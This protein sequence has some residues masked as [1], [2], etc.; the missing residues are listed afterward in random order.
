MQESGAGR[1]PGRTDF[2]SVSLSQTDRVG[3]AYGPLSRE[4]MDNLI[5]LDFNLGQF[6]SFLDDQVGA[7]NYIVALTGDHGVMNAPE[8]EEGPGRRLGARERSLLQD[9]LSAAAREAT[10]SGENGP[11]PRMVEAMKPL[12]FVGP[13]FAHEDLQAAAPGDSIQGF[14]V[15][16]F[17]PGRAGGLL[18]TYGVEMTWAENTISW[19]MPKGTTH[20]SP[21]LY[22]RWVPLFLMGMG[23]ERGTVDDPVQPIDLAP[24]LA[25]LAGIPY[26]ED[27][28][29][30]LL[31]LG[32]GN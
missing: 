29:G 17:T 10:S 22:D 31:P 23:I 18:S 14:F 24:T 15:N 5:R 7:G 3:H 28:D 8:R 12:D 27:L 26:P 11:G 2:L 13:A 16:S 32:G 19:S 30:K 21:Y 4:Q 9:A 25:W 1:T 6:L 20:G